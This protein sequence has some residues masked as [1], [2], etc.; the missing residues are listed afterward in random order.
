MKHR[1]DTLGTAQGGQVE[2]PVEGQVGGPGRGDADGTGDATAYAGGQAPVPPHLVPASATWRSRHL[3][4]GLF[5][6]AATCAVLA[7]V[8]TTVWAWRTPG[9]QRLRIELAVVLLAL[10]LC[11]LLASRQRQVVTLRGS[12]VTVASHRGTESFD[13]ADCMQSVELSG[14]PRQAGWSIVLHRA[15][16]SSLVLGRRDVDAIAVDPIVRHFRH[17]AE[18]RRAQR[19]VMLGLQ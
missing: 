17:L 2:R 16:G 5:T 4:R 6:A 18:K 13:L 19:W 3:L 8:P 11:S 7:V 1:A 15:D 14:D 10:G 9:E 12:S